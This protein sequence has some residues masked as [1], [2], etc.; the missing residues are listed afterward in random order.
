MDIDL[1]SRMIGTLIVEHDQVWL[2]GVGTFV[3]EMMPASFADRGYTIH[4]PYRRLSFYPSQLEDSLLTDLYADTNHIDRESARVYITQF[5]AEMKTILEERKTIVLP[6]LGRLRATRENT[7]F[8]V[9][10]E[11][12]D[13]FPA[14]IGLRPVSLK[15]RTVLDE[16]VEIHVPMPAPPV[17]EPIPEPLPEPEPQPEP[18]PEPEPDPI[19]E[20]LPEPEPEPEP[21]TETEPEPVP[22]PLPEPQ[23]EPQPEKKTGLLTWDPI[24]EPAGEKTA[25]AEPARPAGKKRHRRR[26]WI[27]VA[28]GAAV[29]AVVALASFLILARVA[30]DFIDSL[31]YT[32]EQLRIINY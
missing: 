32:P 19:P 17:P 11:D 14:G 22:E 30:P 8:F 10:D 27:P 2:P 5:L 20:P 24:P 18:Q 31:L 16:P 28:V 26:W 29:L 6:G 1:L 4:P 3:A 15:S 7:L 25:G 13:I 23:P 9:A 21:E 12:L